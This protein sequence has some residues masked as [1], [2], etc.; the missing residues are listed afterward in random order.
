MT[1]LAVHLLLVIIINSFPVRSPRKQDVVE[2]EIKTPSVSQ[3]EKPKTV[4]LAADIQEKL[5][6]QESED[7]LKFLADK[8]QRVKEQTQAKVNGLTKNRTDNSKSQAK[9]AQPAPQNSK[10]KLDPFGT[11]AKTTANSHRNS[12]DLD[13]GVSTN[14]AQLDGVKSGTVTA[15]NTDHYLYYSFFSR[16]TELIYYRWDS[17]VQAALPGVSARMAG[18]GSNDKWTTLVEI[19]LKPNGEFHSAHIMKESGIAEFDRVAT[20]AFRQAGFFPNPPKELV[21]ADGLIRL[22]WG[23]TVYFDPKV[24]AGK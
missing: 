3:N 6:V 11:L 5:K 2:F 17:A 18:K 16:A 13:F 9:A 20:G 7:P 22:K 15:L 14:S 21:E 23:L 4:V 19:W 1:S 12:E 24:L 10:Q 8:V